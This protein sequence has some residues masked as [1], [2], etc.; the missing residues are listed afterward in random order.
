MFARRVIFVVDL[1]LP[2]GDVTEAAAPQRDPAARAVLPHHDLGPDSHQVVTTETYN[3][4]CLPPTL[5]V[6]R[7]D[8][9][10]V[11]RERGDLLVGGCGLCHAW[12]SSAPWSASAR[13]S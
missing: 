12:F 1:P 13:G 8:Q 10:L 4:Q 11:E 3:N 2:E 7:S 5:S 9:T 6:T